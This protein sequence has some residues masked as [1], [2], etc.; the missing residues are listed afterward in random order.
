MYHKG[1]GSGLGWVLDIEHELV[2][3]SLQFS[4]DS[5]KQLPE[6]AMFQR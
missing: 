5:F 2:V 6:V 3:S 1:S 4:T